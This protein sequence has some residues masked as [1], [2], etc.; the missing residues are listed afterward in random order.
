VSAPH[1]DE[2][3]AAARFCIDA[4]KATVPIWKREEWSGG[5]SWGLEPQHITEVDRLGEATA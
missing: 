3:F 1:R 5:A 2:A 4:L